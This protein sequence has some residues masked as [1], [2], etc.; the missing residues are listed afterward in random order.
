MYALSSL[1]YGDR[2]EQNMRYVSSDP[3]GSYMPYSLTI[4]LLA[5]MLALSRGIHSLIDPPLPPPNEML[6]QVYSIYAIRSRST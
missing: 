2:A 3:F 6:K 4:Y 5:I 1:L